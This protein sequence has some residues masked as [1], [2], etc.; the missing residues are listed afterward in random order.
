M[1][2][3]PLLY[4][5]QEK[6]L[7]TETRFPRDCFPESCICF[8]PSSG[9]HDQNH[10]GRRLSLGVQERLHRSG[11]AVAPLFERRALSAWVSF[12]CGWRWRG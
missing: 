12:C 8:S 11:Y 10:A 3:P 1:N 5:R 7:A 4:L 9:R 6:F 2:A